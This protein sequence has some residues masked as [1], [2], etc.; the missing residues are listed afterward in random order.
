MAVNERKTPL[1][2]STEPKKKAPRRN[3]D[4]T[5]QLQL[6]DKLRKQ[7]DELMKRFADGLTL[8]GLANEL[9]VAD[10]LVR[11]ILNHLCI[12]YKLQ[13]PKAAVAPVAIN[14]QQLD[15]VTAVLRRLCIELNHASPELEPFL[16][17]VR[18]NASNTPLS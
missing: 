8:H 12:S 18:A 1:P 9:N 3:L 16:K 10:T 13:R 4:L 11:K 17:I 15:A 14:Q 2:E 7:K 6:A 5:G